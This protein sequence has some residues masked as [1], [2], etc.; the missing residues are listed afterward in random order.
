MNK[1]RIAEVI[2]KILRKQTEKTKSEDVPVKM[3]NL[4]P[5]QTKNTSIKQIRQGKEVNQQNQN[6]EMENLKKIQGIRQKKGKN[7]TQKQSK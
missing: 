1:K 6:P 5:E 2:W 3:E 4:T 7:L